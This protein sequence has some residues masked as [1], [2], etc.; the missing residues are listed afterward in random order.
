MRTELNANDTMVVAT[1]DATWNCQYGPQGGKIRLTSS[2]ISTWMMLTRMWK[3]GTA[4]II[5]EPLPPGK[6]LPPSE[7]MSWE[8]T[9]LPRSAC[10]AITGLASMD[11]RH[12]EHGHSKGTEIREGWIRG[13]TDRISTSE[14]I[15]QQ[16]HSQDHAV[17]DAVQ[18]IE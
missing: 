5:I 18:H 11:V 7:K 6:M 4:S 1:T 14:R 17:A 8:T 9:Q 2:P 10:P 15:S 12:E 3:N 16:C 13:E